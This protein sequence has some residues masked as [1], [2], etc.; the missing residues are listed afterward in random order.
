MTFGIRMERIAGAAKAMRE[1]HREAES[2]VQ[3]GVARAAQELQSDWR[4]QVQRALGLKMSRTIR[5]RVFPERDVSL[6]AAALVWTRSPTVIDAHERGALITA[7]NGL[8]LAIPTAAAGR[9]GRNFRSVLS[10]QFAGLTPARWENATGQ[11]LRFVP[12]PGRHSLL[13]MDDARV[14]RR[15]YAAVN[16]S[17]ARKSDGLRSGAATVPIFVLIR[18]VRLPKRL[19]L[20]EAARTNLNKLPGHIKRSWSTRAGRSGV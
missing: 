6:N 9:G 11:K 18:Q 10:G 12:R 15:G 7:R 5:K 2:A 19:N 3:S 8:Y 20:E 1:A 14:D 4:A 16:R 13:V 17:R